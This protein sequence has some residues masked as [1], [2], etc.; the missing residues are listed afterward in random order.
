MS[1]SGSSYVKPRAQGA[2]GALAA[3]GAAACG[4]LLSVVLL[5]QG[6]GVPASFQAAP[7]EAAGELQPGFLS[8]DFSTDARG[9]ANYSIPLQVPPGTAELQ[10]DIS[11]LYNSHAQDGA[12]GM[13][14]NLFGVS[15]IER[16]QPPTLQ[17]GRVGG[18]RYDASDSFCLDGVLLVKTGTSP[19]GDV[20]RT[21][22]EGWTRVVARGRAGSGPASFLARSKEGISLEFGGTPDSRILAVGRSDVRVWAVDRITDRNGNSIELGFLNNPE[23][24]GAFYPSEIRYTSRAS[25]AP[26]RKLELEYEARP[27]RAPRYFA[28]SPLF[29]NRRLRAVRTLVAVDGAMQTVRRYELQY[30]QGQ[31]T[32]RSRLA[33][34]TEL[35][36]AGNHHPPTVFGWQEG[37]VA[38]DAPKALTQFGGEDYTCVWA[39]LDGNGRDD[40]LCDQKTAPWSH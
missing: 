25:E 36:A 20:Y 27:D 14:W 3:L 13:G 30:G 21:E 22:K 26:L 28:G 37:A 32:G 5:L 9:A 29:Q 24:S 34:V 7:P 17:E 38:L 16:C 23:G 18:V 39:D 6:P 15:S 10:P 19:E 12:L 11:L 35:D 1:W 2:T 31:A 40:L 33:R 8:G 4:A